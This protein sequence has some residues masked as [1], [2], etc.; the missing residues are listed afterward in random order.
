[1]QQEAAKCG[2]SRFYSKRVVFSEH[3]DPEH[4]AR[5]V[6]VAFQDSVQLDKPWQ[7]PFATGESTCAVALESFW[8][9]HTRFRQD[10]GTNAVGTAPLL[11]GRD[12]Q[13]I[14]SSHWDISMART[15]WA[16]RPILR[17]SG[18]LQVCFQQCLR[19]GTRDFCAGRNSG[20]CALSGVPSTH[21]HACLRLQQTPQA[22]FVRGAH[23]LHRAEWDP[24]PR[25]LRV[26]WLQT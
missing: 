20:L 13:L 3:G 23:C 8:S 26:K 6:I 11:L 9:R 7:F 24:T 16:T 21:G 15:S 18:T 5:R 19:Q 10:S 25:L 17:E 12:E 4:R 1:M 22:A 14:A 2:Y